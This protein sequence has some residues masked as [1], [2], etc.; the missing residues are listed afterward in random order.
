M[1]FNLVALTF[2]DI[3]HFEKLRVSLQLS[4]PFQLNHFSQ[5]AIAQV[6][7]SLSGPRPCNFKKVHYVHD[8]VT[9]WIVFLSLVLEKAIIVVLSEFFLN[10]NV[11]ENC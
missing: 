9:E 4:A 10:V 5:A 1:G 11:E 7:L 3:N 2:Y 6:V 8:N